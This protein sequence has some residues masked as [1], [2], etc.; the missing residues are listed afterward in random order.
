MFAKLQNANVKNS[1][2]H[3]LFSFHSKLKISKS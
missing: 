3:V 1:Y 2:E